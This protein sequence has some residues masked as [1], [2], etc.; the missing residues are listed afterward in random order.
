MAEIL[1]VIEAL[2]ATEQR[3]NPDHQDIHQR[4]SPGS[5]DARIGQPFEVID[6]AAGGAGLR[7]DFDFVGRDM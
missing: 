7:A 1:H 3:A 4:V 6:Q 5:I 2:S